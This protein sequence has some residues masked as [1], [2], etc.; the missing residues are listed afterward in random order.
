VLQSAFLFVVS[1]VGWVLYVVY[2]MAVKTLN[3]SAT[4]SGFL[5]VWLDLL[6]RSLKGLKSNEEVLF[7]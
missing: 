6:I 4:F 3:C 5:K 7:F 1:G 2:N